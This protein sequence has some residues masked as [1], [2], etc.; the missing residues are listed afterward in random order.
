MTLCEALSLR[1]LK[2]KSLAMSG[3]GRFVHLSYG[4][5]SWYAGQLRKADRFDMVPWTPVLW[6]LPP[7]VAPSS[8]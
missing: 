5:L 2:N 7:R 3:Q 4:S 1:C 6:A 8:T